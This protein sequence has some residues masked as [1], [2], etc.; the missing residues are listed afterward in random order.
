MIAPD[1][2]LL[3]RRHWL[4][5]TL[6]QL[7][8]RTIVIKSCHRRKL[9]RV[10]L[11]CVAHRN[12]SIRICRIADNQN[13]DVLLCILGNRSTLR[14]KNATIGSQQICALHAIFARHR[15]NQQSNI[16][17]T[18][19]NIGII[20]GDYIYKW[21][22]RTIIKFHFYAVQRAERWCHFK[23]LQNYRRIWPEHLP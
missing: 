4:A 8:H 12:K 2:H 14:L 23:Q 22:I 1:R 11:R 20:G 18:K 10:N 3:D 15:A 17:I 21:R 19:S 5:D 16:S 7:G 9:L 6:G 13:F